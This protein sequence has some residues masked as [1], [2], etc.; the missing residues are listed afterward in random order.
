MLIL[1]VRNLCICPFHRSRKQE[2][3]SP[4]KPYLS[5]P[6]SELIRCAAQVGSRIS[7][8]LLQDVECAGVLSLA[9]TSPTPSLLC[10]PY[11]HA[12]FDPLRSTH[13]SSKTTKDRRLPQKATPNRPSLLRI[14]PSILHMAAT[15]RAAA[16]P[17]GDGSGRAA[18]AHHIASSS[19]A[20]SSLIGPGA[21]PAAK[22]KA[23][24]KKKEAQAQNANAD[25]DVFR[26][27]DAGAALSSSAPTASAPRRSRRRG[28]GAKNGDGENDGFADPGW[29]MPA[30]AA[31]KTEAGASASALTWQQQLLAS[32]MAKSSSSDAPR[33]DRPRSSGARANIKANSSGH[34]SG[35][36]PHNLRDNISSEVSSAPTSSLTWQ[37]ELLGMSSKPTS[38]DRNRDS[39][40]KA[41]NP[42]SGQN[43]QPHRR[44]ASAQPAETPQKGPQTPLKQQSKSSPANKGQPA[45]GGK[46]DQLHIDGPMYAGPNFHNSPSA[47]SLPAPKFGRNRPTSL[48]GDASPQLSSSLGATAGAA[49]PHHDFLAQMQNQQA[50]RQA[51]A[52]QPPPPTKEQTIESLLAKLMR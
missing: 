39:H 16:P 25:D 2:T 13:P 5:R 4:T 3:R 45:K 49:M 27:T 31:S 46:G 14:P 34:S 26:N 20:D 6:A 36:K 50:G 44:G 29:D 40:S 33:T 47:A 24:A 32:T 11:P 7:I 51:E 41:S 23:I 52:L 18:A 35:S 21:S 28:Q 1:V 9:L 43:A 8:D 19:E 10:R 17:E 42:K 22:P 38:S 37:Q 15:T 48:A 30:G 12:S